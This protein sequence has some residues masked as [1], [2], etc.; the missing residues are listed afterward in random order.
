MP[1][2]SSSSVLASTEKNLI[3]SNPSHQI[4]DIRGGYHQNTLPSIKFSKPLLSQLLPHNHPPKPI[5]ILRIR[6]RIPSSV[7]DLLS[8]PPLEDETPLGKHP[9]RIRRPPRRVQPAHH[10]PPPP[11]DVDRDP[12]PRRRRRRRRRRLPFF[13]LFPPPRLHQ[14]PEHPHRL[15]V[16]GVLAAAALRLLRVDDGLH[17]QRQPPQAREP[18]AQRAQEPARVVAHRDV[19]VELEA[20]QGPQLPRQQ[21]HLARAERRAPPAVLAAGVLAEADVVPQRELAQRGRVPQH[22][23]EREQARVAAQ[24]EDLELRGGDVVRHERVQA[25]RGLAAAAGAPGQVRAVVLGAQDA[26]ARQGR[27]ADGREEGEERD[28]EQL[29][30]GE[31]RQVPVARDVAARVLPVVVPQG[32]RRERGQAAAVVG[33]RREGELRALTPAAVAEGR[34]PAGG[35]QELLQ[36]GQR[37]GAERHVARHGQRDEEVRRHG[38]E[39]VVLGAGAVT[40]AAAV[41]QGHVFYVE[42]RSAC[43]ASGVPGREDVGRQPQATGL[44]VPCVEAPSANSKKKLEL[45]THGGG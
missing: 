11:A 19:E 26:Q 33:G 7:R 23:V 22:G 31:A 9:A 34:E 15:R 6:I 40:A 38:P 21:R 30:V 32:Q 3:L 16:V 13:Q 1:S 35:E 45:H 42:F 25:A 27:G 29:Q 20:A 4:S 39:I 43:R 2:P 8:L 44:E 12:L 37:R 14:H 10:D 28:R 17:M 18:A 41:S 36:G 24:V 5:T